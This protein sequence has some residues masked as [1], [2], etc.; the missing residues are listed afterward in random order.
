MRLSVEDQKEQKEQRRRRDEFWLSMRINIAD[1]LYHLAHILPL[2]LS[3]SLS[4]TL[5][6]TLLTPS[7]LLL[8]HYTEIIVVLAPP[9]LTPGSQW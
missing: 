7:V 4:H 2:S 8:G 1:L 5:S 3:L 9:V 6:L